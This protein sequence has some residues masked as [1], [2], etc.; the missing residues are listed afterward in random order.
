MFSSVM[1]SHEDFPADNL[2]CGPVVD[3][4]MSGKFLL[5]VGAPQIAFGVIL[6]YHVGIAL[7]KCSGAFLI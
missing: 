6:Y 1:T 5:A 4:G 2:V 3:D 7:Y